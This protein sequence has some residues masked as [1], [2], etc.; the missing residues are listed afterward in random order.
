MDLST[1]FLKPAFFSHIWGG[2]LLK[3]KYGVDMPITTA[4]H[5]SIYCGASPREEINQLFMRSLK[6]EF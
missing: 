6:K 5:N 4:I 2:T 1:V 3:E